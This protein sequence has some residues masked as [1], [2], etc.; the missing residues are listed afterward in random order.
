MNKVEKLSKKKGI[1]EFEIFINAY[2]YHFGKIDAYIVYEWLLYKYKGKIPD[3][4]KMYVIDE[5]R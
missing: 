3:I 5:L 2:R 1:S 4:V